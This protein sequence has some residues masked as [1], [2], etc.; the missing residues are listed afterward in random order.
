MADFGPGD[1]VRDA[2]SGLAFAPDRAA[3]AVL[4]ELRPSM[5]R[6]RLHRRL[7]VVSMTA[8]AAALVVVGGLS[9]RTPTE[10][11]Q[12]QIANETSGPDEP[13][14]A[15]EV[16]DV[17]SST[18][19]APSTT[20]APTTT[21]VS[22]ETSVVGPTSDVVPAPDADPEPATP[23]PPDPAPQPTSVPAIT[24]PPKAAS[25]KGGR[26]AAAKTDA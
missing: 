3:G 25:A 17:T 11:Q 22:A 23:P 13:L 18:T 6:A 24:T 21:V 14:P 1:P 16:T 19:L 9:L 5:G 4:E 2:L 20:A 26:G 10:A 15:A 12:V 7:Q 8:A